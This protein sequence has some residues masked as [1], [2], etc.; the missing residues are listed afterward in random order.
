MNTFME[1]ARSPEAF[2]RL[3]RRVSIGLLV[4]FVIVMTLLI[5]DIVQ[6]A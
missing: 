5:T 3:A 4:G 2:A 6:R 1:I